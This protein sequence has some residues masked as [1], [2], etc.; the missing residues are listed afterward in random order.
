MSHSKA[1]NSK[2]WERRS[3]AGGASIAARAFWIACTEAFSGFDSSCCLSLAN[4]STR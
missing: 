4:S 1:L 3:I 2:S